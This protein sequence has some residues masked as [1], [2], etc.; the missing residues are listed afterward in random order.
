MRLRQT[1]VISTVRRRGMQLT[2]MQPFL[3]LA[4]LSD[5]GAD[6]ETVQVLC[7]L[8]LMIEVGA[9]PLLCARLTPPK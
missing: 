2:Q 5:G 8:R 3:P 9:A 6:P 1:G 4:S 7:E